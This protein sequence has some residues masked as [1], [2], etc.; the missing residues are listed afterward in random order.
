MI[1]ESLWRARGVPP[2][3]QTPLPR[4]V[5]VAIV[6]GGITGLTAAY[7]LKQAGKRVAVFEREDIGA[8]DTGNTSAHVTYVTDASLGAIEKQFGR[9]AAIRV[10]RGGQAAID[11]IEANARQRGISCGFRRV[12]AFQCA[13][14]LDGAGDTEALRKD[15]DRAREMGFDARFLERGPI[16]GK[17]AIGFSDQAVFHPFEYISGLALAIEGG[18]SLVRVKCEVSQVLDD[19]LAVVVNGETVACEDVILAT[20]VPL[21]GK[22]GLLSATLFQTKLYPYSSYVLGAALHDDSIAPGL[23]FDSSNPYYYLRVHEN[24]DGRYAIF[25]GEDHKTGQETDTDRCFERLV[26]SFSRLVPAA[27]IERRWSGQVIETS[28]GLPFIGATAEHQ[29]VST[30]YAGNGMTFGTLGGMMLHDAVLG[31]R[32]PWSDIFDPDRKVSSAGAIATYISENVDYPWYYVADRVRHPDAGSVDAVAP[33]DGKVLDIDGKRVA[34]HRRGDGSLV[35]VSAVCTH[36]GCLV[37]WNGA[38]T[39]WDCP[40]HGSRFTTDGLVLGGPA[41]TP[42]EKLD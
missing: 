13:P 7:L 17:P 38:E 15:A 42:L 22:T 29:Y 19:P 10:W 3:P 31:R 11:L 39:T 14:F 41:E 25:G 26:H 32:N 30:G 18:G 5:D 35:K 4:Q 34:V 28:D 1:D 16:T 9:D 20:H 12:P 23:Y 33:G 24:R 8:G 37:R 6:G 27:T 36:M 2:L 40:C 21:A